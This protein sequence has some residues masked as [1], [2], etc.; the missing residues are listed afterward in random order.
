MQ[1]LLN[2]RTNTVHIASNERDSETAACGSLLH[3]PEEQ[4]EAIP[5]TDLRTNGSVD[6]CGNCF[7]EVGG[8]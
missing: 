1:C 5:K 2:T 6:R 8:Y 3:V 4:V 7:E